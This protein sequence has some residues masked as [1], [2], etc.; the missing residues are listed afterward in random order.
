M[1][2]RKIKILAIDDNR[3]NLITLKALI[4]DEFPQAEV[5]TAT[6]GRQ[7]L[8]M[9]SLEAP[10]VVLLDIIMPGMDGYEVCRRMK[11]DL[12]LCDIPVVFITAIKGTK[13]SRIKALESGAEAFLGK[14]IDELELTAQ[15]RAM[16]KIRA[17]NI[18]K[19]DEKELLAALVEEKT[20]ELKD[21][22]T[23]MMQLLDSMRR[24][25]S[26]I[27]AIFD[28]I[29]GYLYVYDENRNLVR[30]NRKHETMTGY[31][32]EDLSHMNM[33]HWFDEE[34][35]PL[36]D[37]AIH[38]VFEKGYG[39]V[40]AP[41]IKKN[42]ERMMTRSSGAP[43]VWDGKKFFTGIG[44]DITEQKKVQDA[45][46]ASQSI[47]K[48]AFENSQTGI[49]IADA[50]TG[51]IRYVNKAG[52]LIIDKTEEDFVEGYDSIAKYVT[53]GTTLHLDGTPYEN[54]EF[55]LARALLNGETCTEEFIV[56]RDNLKD[57]YVLANAAPIRD[58]HDMIKAGVIVFLDI[59]ERK[60]MEMRLKQNMADL[61]ESQRIAQ[62]GT[63]R[64]DLMTNEVVLSEEL[65]KMYGFDS[66][67]PTPPISEHRK[68]YTEESWEHLLLSMEHTKKYGV[69]YEI[70]L[71][72]TNH[73][74]IWARGQAVKDPNGNV[75]GLWGA[76]QEITERKKNERDL[77]YL[78]N[79]DHLT[80]LHN[81]RY[82]EETLKR[83]DTRDNLPLS[84]IMFDVNG[85]KLVN[86]SFGHDVGDLLLKATAKTI[87]TSCKGE[88]LTARMGGDEFIVILPRT[89]TAETARIANHIK[90]CSSEEKVDNIELSLSFGYDTK[91]S[92]TD[93]INEIIANAE[94]HM[95]SHKLYER[96]SIRSKT[97]DL[98]MNTL[99]EK[100]DREAMHSSR[101]GYMCQSIAT[102]M[103]LSKDKVHQMRIAG[104]IH[105]I[106]KIGVDETILNKPGKLTAE[107]RRDIERHST[108]G[109]KILSSA[110]EFSELSQFVLCHHENWDGSGY[111]NGLKGSEI[112]LEANII[113]IADSYDAMTSNRSY[114]EGMSKEAAV[115]ELKR[116]SGTHFNPAIVEIF[117]NMVLPVFSENRQVNTH[118]ML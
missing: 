35:M 86:D 19:R 91:T 88:T 95:Y 39:E 43:L 79:H 73:G 90:E 46:L 112:P 17:A 75:T 51:S 8:E 6:N 34:H 52:L 15:I 106:G 22:N 108:I 13:E 38:D 76:T 72:T 81:R 56:R 65:Y 44:L 87:T 55:P 84:V 31:S 83:M 96:S 113:R 11:E 80:G 59:T 9:A 61:L 82:F 62:V 23:K 103:K 109:W 37:D 28:S 118:F 64:L 111:P 45:L 32:A 114:R 10:D 27:E 97:I 60:T 85:L 5:L 89:T 100:S 29:P 41:L 2:N 30:W 94:N 54:E 16:L 63:W 117:V 47:L 40:E 1:G 48:A 68:F 115:A 105:D 53:Y 66:S 107:E 26:F 25:Q 71:E 92:E 18:Q 7:G 69:P 42:G 74:W 93:S 104:L 102:Q 24:D 36:V 116:C 3:D 67:L 21:S 49:V 77:L 99:F 12:N 4:Q 70:E 57:R 50:P 98:I 58:A 14:P 20:K 33:S 101:V 78:S 110:N